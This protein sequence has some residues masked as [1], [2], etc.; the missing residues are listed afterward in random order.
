L[1]D[2]QI[3]ELAVQTCGDYARVVIF[4]HARLRVHRAPGIPHA[5]IFLGG[6]FMQNSGG[7]RRGN[8]AP[9]L[10]VI[11]RSEAT[12][13]SIVTMPLYGLLRFARNDG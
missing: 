11:A 5:L 1:P 2:G 8:A 10:D 13:Q 4:S 6:W 12:K 7:L 3:S 9:R